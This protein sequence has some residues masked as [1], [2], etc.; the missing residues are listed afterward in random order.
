MKQKISDLSKYYEVYQA[1][2]SESISKKD[3]LERMKATM[4]KG[5]Y[6]SRA[7]ALKAG[8]IDLLTSPSE[9]VYQMDYYKLRAL[10]EQLCKDLGTDATKMFAGPAPAAKGR[11]AEAPDFGKIETF[12]ESPTTK[13]LK[14]ENAKLKS[15]LTEMK[16]QLDALQK[17]N[18]DQVCDA[19]VSSMERKVFIS[20]S[21]EG[22]G[23]V[24]DE[25]FFCH[26]PLS[27]LEIPGETGADGKVAE[28]CYVAGKNRG[29]SLTV[30]N[31]FDKATT[32]LFRG[33]FFRRRFED[34]QEAKK[35]ELKEHREKKEQK[36]S[37][38][39]LDQRIHQN[40]KKSIDEL[41]HTPL[42]NQAKLAIYAGMHEYHGTEL[43]D[44][45]NYAGD[46]GLEA[47]YVIQLLESPKEY[48]NFQ[49]VRGFLRQ[50][51]KSS[52]ARMKRVAAMELIS[53]EWYVVASYNGKPTRF[54]MVP[55][56]ELLEFR[57]AL[58]EH[59]S[60]RA[61]VI[62]EKMLGQVRKAAFVDDNP[63]KDIVVKDKGFQALEEAHLE[64]ANQRMQQFY[65]D[66]GV[67]VYEP[68]DEDD[69]DGFAEYQEASDGK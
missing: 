64:E 55:V 20:S 8:A 65:A 69:M 14:A 25:D 4:K 32:A 59:M 2:G 29:M 19:I 33:S 15:Q 54:Q 28:S 42:D 67:N 6:D 12:A 53:G 37:E 18:V 10:V 5:T 38:L 9:E 45:L 61:L 49:N 7:S 50:A 51:C 40:R 68:I 60:D 27:L 43:E 17:Q 31:A 36:E 48:D 23:T 24:F 35:R 46:H 11:K 22:V 47:D 26:T 13:Q 44:L 66:K 58:T 62:L 63:E 16:S 30:K 34:V 41:L 52:E 57:N 1:V 56:D 3:L 39:S 21:I